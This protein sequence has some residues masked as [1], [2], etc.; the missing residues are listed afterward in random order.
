ML[1]LELAEICREYHFLFAAVALVLPGVTLISDLWV[2]EQLQS[3]GYRLGPEL[4]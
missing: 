4:P 1:V 2:W 3:G